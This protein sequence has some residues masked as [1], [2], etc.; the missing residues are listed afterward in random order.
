M[1]HTNTSGRQTLQGKDGVTLERKYLYLEPET[2]TALNRLVQAT[3]QNQSTL[4]ATL[5][6]NAGKEIKNDTSTRNA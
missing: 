6:A 2:W 1:P 3:Q 5:I 4:I